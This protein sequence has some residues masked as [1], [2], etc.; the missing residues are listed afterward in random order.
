MKIMQVFMPVD[1][2]QD[3]VGSA[4]GQN[5]NNDRRFGWCVRQMSIIA[6]YFCHS[7]QSFAIRRWRR[8]KADNSSFAFK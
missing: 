1:Y 4:F 7:Q 2:S 5:E 6:L 3:G 8:V